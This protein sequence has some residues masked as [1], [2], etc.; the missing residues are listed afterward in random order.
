[1][2]AL[3]GKTPDLAAEHRELLQQLFPDVFEEGKLDFDKLRQVL[4]EYTDDEK[5]RYHFTWN[6]K[7]RALRLSQT[8]TFGTLRPCPSESVQWAET[9][10]LYLEGDN[11]EVLKL[12]QKSYHGQ[13]KMIYIDPPYNTGGDFVYPDDFSDS[14]QNYKQITGQVDR[15]GRRLGTNTEASGRY[16]TDWLNMIYPR[17]RL[18]RNL[19]S[20]DGVMFIS[21]DE[22]ELDNLT[23]ISNEIF[24]EYNHIGTIVVKS[25]PRGSMSA[26]EIAN[27]H[28]YLLLYSKHRPSARIIGH[29]LTAEMASEYHYTDENGAYRLLGLRM[30]GGFWRRSQRPNLY[31][32][33]FVNP[34][35]G[36]VSLERSPV[37]CEE[38]YPVQPSTME[39]G[40]WRWS[41]EKVSANTGLL[42]G[43][44]VERGDSVIW[45]IYQKD[46]LE[47]GSGRRTKAKSIWDE[48]ELNYQNGAAEIRALL[49]RGGIFDY[50]KPVF[51]LKQA[52]KMVEFEPGDLV[53]DF[54]SGSATTAH[55]VMQVNAEDGIRRRFMMIQL[56]EPCP[57]G[58]EAAG[59]GY[60]TICD[61][62]KARIRRA[63]EQLREEVAAYN[64]QRA[65]GDPPREVPDIGFQVF[66]LDSSNLK[67]WQPDYEDLESTLFDSIN[68][69]VEGRS[70]LDVVYE[71]MLKTGQVLTAPLETHMIAGRRVYLIGTGALMICLDDH[72]TAEVAE[73]MAALLRACSPGVWRAVFRDNGFASDSDK[74][75]VR[76]ILKLA[77]LEEDA[78]LTI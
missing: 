57:A 1:M 41:R 21:I 76:E 30:R 18:A 37:Y 23:K 75:N 7:G 71:I 19:L 33:L 2:T 20:E 48:S 22:H 36:A 13:V 46:Y 74:I 65:A 10:N 24:G 66:T 31:F 38:T 77:G 55:A 32:P 25:N 62:G 63:G 11:L 58:S 67:T 14:I 70:D 60:R 54:F 40:T 73:G 61:I 27:M 68:N 52:L 34:E 49:G 26:S 12:L 6:G 39:A 35:T 9:Q 72:I 28:E 47:R 4:G 17:L 64:A 56:P 44:R 51:L 16:H 78:F 15:E 53:L 69:Y 29:E 42:V 43:R 5:E 59:A 8:P 45:D 3:T 50:A